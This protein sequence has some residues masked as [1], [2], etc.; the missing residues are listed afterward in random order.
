MKKTI[1]LFLSMLLLLSCCGQKPEPREAEVIIHEIID[2]YS[3]TPDTS[4]D[5]LFSEL[6][7]VDAQKASQWRHIMD[8]WQEQAERPVPVF[9]LP[10]GL[11]EDDSLCL[12]VLG[13][14]LNPDGTMQD[15]L[16]G[17]LGV[18]LRCAMQYPNAYVL[19]T[20]GGTASETPEVTEAGLMG[21]WLLDNGLSEERL[22]MEDQSRTTEENALFSYGIL[23]SKAPAVRSLCI[24]TSSYHMTWG[25]VLF[26]AALTLNRTEE[27]DAICVVSG[28]A[29]PFTNPKY[30]DPPRYLQM[31]M[32][33][34]A[35]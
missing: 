11:P 6:E 35:R 21:Q 5:G 17:R 26:E 3:A 27:D 20:G 18:A 25:S 9:E 22:L 28:A 10:T 14:E 30:A 24:I 13:F 4:L 32:K 7:G 1:L 34:L 2:T 15:E 23:R 29:Y 16:L 19:C 31:Q 12:V 33:S 8:F